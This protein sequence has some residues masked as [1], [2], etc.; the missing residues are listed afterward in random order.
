DISAPADHPIG[1]RDGRFAAHELAHLEARSSLAADVEPAAVPLGREEYAVVARD[2]LGE[3]CIE[4]YDRPPG[5]ELRRAEILEPMLW[6]LHAMEHALAAV[7]ERH[8]GVF[9]GRGQRAGDLDVAREKAGEGRSVGGL[10][11]DADVVGKP[12]HPD[13]PG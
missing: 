11:E 3:V 5:P 1:E 2:H 4:L 6:A 13:G 9:H 12:D 7:G 8:H 10:A